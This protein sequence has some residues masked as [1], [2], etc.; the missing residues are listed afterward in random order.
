MVTIDGNPDPEA[1]RD[2]LAAT[3]RCREQPSRFEEWGLRIRTARAFDEAGDVGRHPTMQAFV[4]S[5]KL[6]AGPGSP[7]LAWQ[8]RLIGDRLWEGGRAVFP[9]QPG[10]LMPVAPP[11][12]PVYEAGLISPRCSDPG[13]QIT[14]ITLAFA[15][16]IKP[17]G[18]VFPT[19]AEP[20]AKR[21]QLAVALAKPWYRGLLPDF[22]H[23]RAKVRC[24]YF[25]GLD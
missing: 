21:V 17:R 10:L 4:D 13:Y 5:A 2:F 19:D 20:T 8:R 12:R 23:I 9:I 15:S 3:D 14:G 1:H 25:P 7:S 11:A 16:A 18:W 24:D 6:E 22:L